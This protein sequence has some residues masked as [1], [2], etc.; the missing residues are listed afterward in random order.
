[1]TSIGTITAI[2]IERYVIISRS[3]Y[4]QTLT[5]TASVIVIFLIWAYSL[6][7]ALPPL[8]GWNRYIVEHPGIACSLD[9]QTPDHHHSSF[10]IYIF[11]L[12]YIL[13]VFIMTYCYVKVIFILRKVGIS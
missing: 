1:M 6:V 13:P 5:S 8:V 9:W 10:I 7:Q 3:L 11:V 12:G 4:G 2:A